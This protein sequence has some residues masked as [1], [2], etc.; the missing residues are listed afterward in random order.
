MVLLNFLL[1][2]SLTLGQDLLKNG[3]LIGRPGFNLLTL[4]LSNFPGDS[5]RFLHPCKALSLLLRINLFR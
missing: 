5:I 2:R 4:H 3:Y 1:L